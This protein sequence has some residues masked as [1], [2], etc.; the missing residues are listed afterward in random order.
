MAE[1]K[2][3]KTIGELVD[4]FLTSEFHSEEDCAL[5]Y[6]L[7]NTILDLGVDIRVLEMENRLLE[8]QIA[9]AENAITRLNKEKDEIYTA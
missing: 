4:D 3:E 2:E 6:V 5:V 7:Y 1:E 9:I 8:R